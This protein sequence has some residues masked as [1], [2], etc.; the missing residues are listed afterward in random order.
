M[1]KTLDFASL[2]ESA[3]DGQHQLADPDASLASDAKASAHHC[4][5]PPGGSKPLALPA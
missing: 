1:L 2:V 5:A 3:S 4:L